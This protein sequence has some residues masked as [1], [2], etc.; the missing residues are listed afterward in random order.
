M[1]QQGGGRSDDLG[2]YGFTGY[3]GGRMNDLYVSKQYR[4]Y[5]RLAKL[6][7]G[8]SFHS[9]RPTCASWLV[10]RGASL[11]IVQHILGHG[12][13]QVTQKYTHLAPDVMKAAMEQAFGVGNR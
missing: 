7:E 12:D 5:R 10:Q 6:P 4:T 3:T 1:L 11:S 9:L 2:G 8:L 13:I